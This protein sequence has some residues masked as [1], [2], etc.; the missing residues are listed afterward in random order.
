MYI[1]G[2]TTIILEYTIRD[3]EVVDSVVV[4]KLW[5]KL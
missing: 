1:G 2:K 4:F 3:R 5:K